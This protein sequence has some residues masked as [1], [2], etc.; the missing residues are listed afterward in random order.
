MELRGDR[1]QSRSSRLAQSSSR[2]HHWTA[3]QKPHRVE[4]DDDMRQGLGSGPHPPEATSRSRPGGCLC[5]GQV[6]T[7]A[8]RGQTSPVRMVR[9]T[10]V[11][12]PPSGGL[13]PAYSRLDSGEAE[14][15]KTRRSDGARLGM[16]PSRARA[17]ALWSARPSA[18]PAL[19]D[20]V[21][22]AVSGARSCIWE[23][24]GAMKILTCGSVAADRS[25]PFC[26]LIHL[27]FLGS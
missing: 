18:T 19:D 10:G 25:R 22:H 11:F 27:S 16:G 8:Q 14:T 2:V 20:L 23:G 13:A 12:G 24:R 17:R 7:V 26:R 15:A 1:I 21:V 9:K 5:H 4:H 3:P 6:L